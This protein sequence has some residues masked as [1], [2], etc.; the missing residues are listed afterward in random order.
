VAAARFKAIVC[1]SK[2]LTGVC[3]YNGL[4]AIAACYKGNWPQGAVSAVLNLV[5]SPLLHVPKTNGLRAS[6]LELASLPELIDMFRMHEATDRRDKIYALL[7]MS[8]NAQL[9]PDYNIVWSSVFQKLIPE[10][11]GPTANVTIV[12]FEA[13]DADVSTLTAKGCIIGHASAIHHAHD[14]GQVICMSP[15]LISPV[16]RYPL[17]APRW[18]VHACASPIREGDLIALVEGCAEFTIVRP[19]STA[20]HIIALCS[21]S[22]REID[23]KLALS[24]YLDHIESLQVY[25]SLRT[26]HLIWA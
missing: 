9:S 14:G 24:T 20:L 1:G 10:I 4:Q 16:S 22:L 12:T 15:S 8:K 25:S 5:G 13:M 2:E 19:D 26:L 7:G 11:L 23:E 3:F 17:Q 18:N 6:S 21:G